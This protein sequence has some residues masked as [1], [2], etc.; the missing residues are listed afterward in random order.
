MSK[1]ALSLSTL[2]ELAGWLTFGEAARLLDVS[3]ERI[4]QMATSKGTGR[5]RTA[6]RL[7]KRPVGIV[8]EAEIREILARRAGLTTPAER[9]AEAREGDLRPCG[10][11][12]GY[13]GV[14]PE[15]P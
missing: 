6:H 8:R 7:G 4:R 1:P 2:P 12:R 10:P 9:E 3:N 5:L 11:A 14:Q 15:H 13:P